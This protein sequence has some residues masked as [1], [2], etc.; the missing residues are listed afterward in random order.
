MPETKKPF[1]AAR[2]GRKGGSAKSD[3]KTVA[4]RL[5]A[6]KGGRKGGP[7]KSK[8]KTL[9]ARM[10][11]RKGGHPYVYH[12]AA[13]YNF[14]SSAKIFSDGIPCPISQEQLST[15]KRAFDQ[16]NFRLALVKVIR[17]WNQLDHDPDLTDEEQQALT[18][19]R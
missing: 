3:R 15:L 9:A 6:S 1:D 5:N 12:L 14:T 7:A 2:L 4:A 16:G 8:R 11:G 19:R 18:H 13:G 17:F 10:N